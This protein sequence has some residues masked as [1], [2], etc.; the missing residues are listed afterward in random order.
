MRRN[1][2]KHPLLRI[3]HRSCHE[4][5]HIPSTH[6]FGF[7]AP[8]KM[9]S[10]RKKCGILNLRKTW[11]KGPILLRERKRAGASANEIVSSRS[12]DLPAKCN[13]MTEGVS[14]SLNANPT[15]Q[16]PRESLNSHSSTNE[17]K[18]EQCCVANSCK[19]TGS[20]PILLQTRVRGLNRE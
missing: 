20:G 6:N 9:S 19:S 10:N 16:S 4:V 13:K 1:S 14:G 5:P 3:L 7:P 11:P 12:R 2:Q 18:S 17:E 8:C 15:C